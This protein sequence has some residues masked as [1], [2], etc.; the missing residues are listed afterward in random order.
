M[1]SSITGTITHIGTN[2]VEIAAN[3]V[4]YK[5]YTTPDIIALARV[6]TDATMYTHTH[7]REDALDLFGFD[8]R[9][10]LELFEKLITVSGIGPKTALGVLSLASVAD[11]ESAIVRGDAAILTKVSGIG[12]KTA[13]RIVLEL[14]GKISAEPKLGGKETGV[15]SEDSDVID[16]LVGLGYSVDEARG[17]LKKIDASIAG[18]NE[19]VKAAL[20]LLGKR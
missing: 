11:I 3:S 8:S 17:A 12:K 10:K 2:F 14:A 4:G 6:G 1:I 15:H 16:A 5:V 18:V 19:K 13:E 7:V 9:D 20:R